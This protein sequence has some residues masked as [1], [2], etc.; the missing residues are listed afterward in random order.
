MDG[1][2][3]GAGDIGLGLAPDWS[4]SARVGEVVALVFFRSGAVRDIWL[5]RSCEKKPNANHITPPRTENDQ[6]G[7]EPAQYHPPHPA[8]RRDISKKPPDSTFLR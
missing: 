3:G 4:F 8:L 1:R 5:L 2:R 7:A 6:S